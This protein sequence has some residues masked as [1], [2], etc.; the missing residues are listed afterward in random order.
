M[1]FSIKEIILI[2]LILCVLYLL[3]SSDK[4]HFTDDTEIINAVNKTINDRYSVDFNAMR[5]LGDLS[6]NILNL[7]DTD[8]FTIPHKGVQTK[9]LEVD[10]LNVL[11]DKNDLDSIILN[12]SKFKDTLRI[13]KDCVIN[14][15]IKFTNLKADSIN[16]S[17]YYKNN[18]F[19]KG[20]ILLYYTEGKADYPIP[21]G[22]AP[23]DG[24]YY[25]VVYPDDDSSWNKQL[26]VN[27]DGK[28]VKFYKQSANQAEPT[29][30]IK[31][32]FD[33]A[34]TWE[35]FF[36]TEVELYKLFRAGEPDN[37]P[38]RLGYDSP[39]YER[40]Y[41]IRNKFT[42]DDK[43]YIKDWYDYLHPIDGQM[44][45]NP[46][47]TAPTK[48]VSPKQRLIETPIDRD[49]IYIIKILDDFDPTSVSSS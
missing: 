6:S 27:K 49:Y 11:V 26:G 1:I 7:K 36:A 20:T 23:C 21:Y 15:K 4:E 14:N 9:N 16:V 17:Q 44:H 46:I 41:G 47:I 8:E 18:I 5:K 35:A 29:N 43:R 25:D 13:R 12:N 34:H 45:H 31:R 24:Y 39:G 38:F 33:L 48:Q 10:E 40:L 19:P 2:I 22:W 37:A 28:H 30:N 32:N 42:D 3:I